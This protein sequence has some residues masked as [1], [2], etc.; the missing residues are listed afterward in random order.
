VFHVADFAAQIKAFNAKAVKKVD[1]VIQE[2]TVNIATAL[3]ERTPIDT[4]ALRANWQFTVGE[5][6]TEADYELHDLG[7]AT[8]EAIAE[9]ARAVPAGNVTFIVNNLDYM[10]TIEYGLYPN[11]PKKSG[12]RTVNG[13]ST[14]APGP[15]PPGA[16]RGLTAME[17]ET[18]VNAAVAKA[19]L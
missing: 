6:G 7:N 13:F 5:P 16:V 12:G 8:V 10:R 1:T 4:T 14:Q 9:Q 2:A 18:F 11:P 3:V 15:N 17:W 19:N